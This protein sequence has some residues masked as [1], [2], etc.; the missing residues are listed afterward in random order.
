MSYEAKQARL[1]RLLEEADSIDEPFD[2][3]SDDEEEAPAEP[4]S[5]AETEQ[6][7]GSDANSD[8]ELATKMSR[9][10]SFTGK[11]GTTIWGK[12]VPTKSRR[13]SRHNI[14]TQQPGVTPIST[15]AKSVTDCWNL[16]FLT[17]F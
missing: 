13:V 16:F 11:D 17:I 8:I 7:G 9:I 12:H 3:D 10:S 4:F 2:D 14:V 15:E 5:D 6:E 1:L